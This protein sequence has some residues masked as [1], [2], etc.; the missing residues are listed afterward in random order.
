MVHMNVTVPHHQQG[1]VLSRLRAAKDLAAA[2]DRSFAEFPLSEAHGLR[3]TGMISKCLRES[4]VILEGICVHNVYCRSMLLPQGESFDSWLFVLMFGPISS[5][6][7]A[8]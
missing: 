5:D 7:F 6:L 2:R 8:F 1:P 4:R 3:V